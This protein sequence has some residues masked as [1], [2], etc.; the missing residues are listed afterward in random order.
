[1]RGSVHGSSIL[2]GGLKTVT[3]GR[4]GKGREGKGREGK[5][6]EGKG[7]EGKGREGNELMP[8]NLAVRWGH[9]RM[10]STSD[11]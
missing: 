8:L 7:R 6:R 5:G 4:G 11:D 2:I 9:C 3:V 10:H 1:M